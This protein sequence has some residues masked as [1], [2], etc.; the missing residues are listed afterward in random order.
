AYALSTL[1]M[2]VAI[3]FLFVKVVLLIRRSQAKA[4]A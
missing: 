3:A 4:Q 1:M 2:A